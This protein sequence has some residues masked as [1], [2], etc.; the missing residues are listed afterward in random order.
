MLQSVIFFDRR[1]EDELTCFISAFAFAFDGYGCFATSAYNSFIKGVVGHVARGEFM[2]VFV[3]EFVLF[4]FFA[5]SPPINV[6]AVKGC[7]LFVI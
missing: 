5:Y 4:I 3:V 1:D 2:Q 6:P 7:F